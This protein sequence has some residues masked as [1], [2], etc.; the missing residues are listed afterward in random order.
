MKLPLVDENDTIV[1]YKQKDELL[2]TDIYRVSR[3]VVLNSKGQIL[4]AQRA[5]TKQKDPGAWGLAV[6]G[7]VEKGESYESNIRKEAQE[8]I[9]ITLDNIE[10]GPK[11]R[12]KG[13]F[14]HFSQVFI[15]RIEIDADKLHLQASEV[16][17][18]AWYDVAALQRESIANPNK[19]GYRF[20]DILDVILPSIR[21][22]K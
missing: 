7:T 21:N 5:L 4:M 18:V 2:S 8:E 10:Y 6:E 9:G 14:N 19:F 12:R 1:G 20:K 16:E 17:R 13:K 22:E 3:L 11:F 15:C